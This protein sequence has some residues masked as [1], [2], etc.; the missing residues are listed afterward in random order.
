[1]GWRGK[2][3]Q[4]NIVKASLLEG[5]VDGLLGLLV[6]ESAWRDLGREEDV[7]TLEPR[8][9]DRLGAGGFVSVGS[10]GVDLEGRC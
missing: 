8:F 4:I 7:F 1:M 3:L 2:S 6:A 9:T 10:G 5:G